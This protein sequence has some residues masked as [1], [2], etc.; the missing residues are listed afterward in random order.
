M[1]SIK[2]SELRTKTKDQLN[3]Q[4]TEYKKEQFNLRFQASNGQLNNTGRVKE[5]RRG[6]AKVKGLLNEEPNNN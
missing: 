6:I 2:I 4:L 3:A 5:V 1:V